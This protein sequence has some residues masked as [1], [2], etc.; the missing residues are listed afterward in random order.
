[1]S[2]NHIS[3]ESNQGFSLNSGEVSQQSR[4]IASTLSKHMGLDGALQ[5]STENQWYSVVAALNEI[6]SEQR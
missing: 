1:M 4:M 6:K 5:I 3:H 2:S